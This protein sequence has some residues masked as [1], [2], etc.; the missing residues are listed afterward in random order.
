LHHLLPTVHAPPAN[1]AFGR[2]PFAKT[3]GH[4]AGFA[5]GLGNQ[6]GVAFGI[7]RPFAYAAGRID[8]DDAVGPDAQHSE[9]GGDAAGFENLGDE[10]APL[11]RGAHA[12]PPSVGPQTGAT[13][14]P[15]TNP[16]ARTLSASALI[17]SSVALML[18]CGSKRNRSTP[19]NFAPLTE[20]LAVKASIVSRSM[21]GSESGPLPTRPGDM[22]LW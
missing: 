8:P 18:T 2:E 13:T 16:L 4:V 6:L 22:A 5:E 19:S 14:E 7:V 15:M 20:A 17:W 12:E 9:L 11:F 10:L 3:L 21:G 1:L